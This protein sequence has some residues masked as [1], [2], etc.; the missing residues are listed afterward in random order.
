MTLATLA[1]FLLAPAAA[2]LALLALG[3]RRRLLREREAAR[4]TLLEHEARARHEAAAA[5]RERIY[6]NL[7]D[8]LGAGLLELVHG[9]SSPEAADRARALLQDLR[10]V[11]SRSRGAPGTLEEILGE[12]RR[13]AGQRL[14]AA[15][16]ELDWQCPAPLPE[17]RID[18]A[19]AL[20]LYRIVR[21]AISNAI[22][23]AAAQRIRVRVRADAELL[24]LELTD[25]GHF[26]EDLRAGGG[27]GLDN[28]R[29]RAAELAGRIDWRAGTVGGTKVL[30]SIPLE[31]AE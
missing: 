22:R 1:L 29:S 2:A 9:A 8:D 19:R 14:G 30:L 24:H 5:E 3:L 23:H 25:D 20:H 12:I 7:H 15:R 27:R 13:E 18:T 17:V 16:I 10:D 11:V 21:E 4:R 28:M 31:M 26:G 6:A